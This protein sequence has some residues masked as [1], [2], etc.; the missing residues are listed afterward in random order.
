MSAK[1]KRPSA[2]DLYLA[3]QW[4][5]DIYEGAED[6]AACR[7]VA[8]WL[9]QQ[10]DDAE[11][12]IECRKAGV[13]VRLARKALKFQQTMKPDNHCQERKRTS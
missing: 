10:A 13:S 2:D 9:E 3:A 6:A 12:A 7:R 11:F 8:A 1:V 5:E 4:L